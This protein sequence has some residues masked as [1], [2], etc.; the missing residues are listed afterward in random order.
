MWFFDKTNKA[1]KTLSGFCQVKN[2]VQITMEGKIQ[3][4]SSFLLRC[5]PGYNFTSIF[6]ILFFEIYKGYS[7]LDSVTAFCMEKQENGLS[8]FSL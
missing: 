6:V 5:D 8:W 1:E 7:K 3:L 2:K 4:Y